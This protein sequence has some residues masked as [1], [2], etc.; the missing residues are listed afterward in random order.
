MSDETEDPLSRVI[1][2]ATQV[3]LDTHPRAFQLD[4]IR[5]TLK[6]NSVP[7]TNPNVPVLLVQGTGGGKSFAHQTIGMIKTDICLTTQNALSLSSH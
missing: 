7:S 1:V 5:H 3:V 6:I 4:V 2:N